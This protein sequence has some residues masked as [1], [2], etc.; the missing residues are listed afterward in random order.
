MQEMQKIISNP[1]R[2]FANLY[3]WQWGRGTGQLLPQFSACFLLSLI[4]L[5]FFFSP[6]NSNGEIEKKKG[7]EMRNAVK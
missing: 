3:F 4:P 5:L 7:G 6:S 1:G 2:F